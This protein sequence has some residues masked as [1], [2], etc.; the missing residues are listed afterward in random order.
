MA[1]RFQTKKLQ[2]ILIH[3]ILFRYS[4]ELKTVNSVLRQ[5]QQIEQEFNLGNYNFLFSFPFRGFFLEHFVHR[6]VCL[7]LSRPVCSSVCL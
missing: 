3:F 2:L 4:S 7:S 5:I 1:L 6:F